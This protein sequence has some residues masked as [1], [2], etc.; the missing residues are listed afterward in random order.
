MESTGDCCPGCFMSYECSGENYPHICTKCGNVFDCAGECPECGVKLIPDFDG[1][2]TVYVCTGNKLQDG[3]RCE[4]FFV[5]ETKICACKS[6]CEPVT[7]AP[8]FGIYR[9]NSCFRLFFDWTNSKEMVEQF[10]DEKCKKGGVFELIS[11]YPSNYKN[12]C[13]YCGYEYCAH[14]LKEHTPDNMRCPGCK[15]FY[16][17]ASLFRAINGFDILSRAPEFRSKEYYEFNS[18]AIPKF[19]VHREA[20]VND[21]FKAILKDRLDD[22]VRR[23]RNEMNLNQFI[24]FCIL[25]SPIFDRRFNAEAVRATIPPD[26]EFE[27]DV[28]MNLFINHRRNPQVSIA[29]IL[30]A[31]DRF[32]RY[33]VS[34]NDDDLISSE[35]V[36]GRC[37][38]NV[39]N[40]ET[41]AEEPCCG[42]ILRFTGTMISKC[43]C[44]SCR[45]NY[46]P[47]CSR[48]VKNEHEHVCNEN[49]LAMVAKIGDCSDGHG[50]RP[51]PW[52][53][54]MCFRDMYCST[55]WCKECHNFFDMVSGRKLE[56]A[57]HH[58]ADYNE[59]LLS[60]GT[61]LS[62]ETRRYELG[63]GGRADVAERVI[64]Y[65]QEALNPILLKDISPILISLNSCANH[66]D[67]L[68]RGEEIRNRLQARIVK[69]TIN[70]PR[71]DKM[72]VIAEIEREIRRAARSMLMLEELSVEV[73]K[74]NNQARDLLLHFTREVKKH[75]D[76][77]SVPLP[78]YT[79]D[80]AFEIEKM[81]YDLTISSYSLIPIFGKSIYMDTF[82]N[83]FT[84]FISDSTNGI[85]MKIFKEDG[86]DIPIGSIYLRQAFVLA[87]NYSQ[88][89]WSDMTGDD[90]NGN[91]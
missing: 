64:N 46:C 89:I 59:Y 35:E 78:T 43:Y 44:E 10:K 90:A 8:H 83:S 91:M 77:P 15:S 68:L 26:K 56:S 87:V 24:D 58:N 38:L 27:W 52:C 73:I 60:L 29:V 67:D 28:V 72:E 66:L 2:K 54:V 12:R 20:I 14:C 76:D 55:M 6:D 1:L 49:D 25:S 17:L 5:S 21:R 37:E 11:R 7:L 30:E 4:N 19:A 70:N 32:K 65:C 9:C 31:F 47:K 45:Q 39:K 53:G 81:I 40:A 84:Q 75:N 42:R 51:C 57:P 61:N 33:I 18:L 48:V 88:L 69:A 71:A 63:R 22:H 13:Q 34:R 86:L 74:F 82:G 16:S 79:K 80:T 41:G 23:L 50:Y 62:E 85:V 3:R 36:I